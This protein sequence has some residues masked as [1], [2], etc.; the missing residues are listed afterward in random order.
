MNCP[1]CGHALVFDFTAGHPK[2]RHCK[3]PAPPDDIR[4]YG[5]KADAVKKDNSSSDKP[6]EAVRTGV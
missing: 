3:Y 1:G 6:G 2:C 4:L 5:D